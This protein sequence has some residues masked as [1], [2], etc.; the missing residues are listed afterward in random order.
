MPFLETTE[1]EPKS[2]PNIACQI[3]GHRQPNKFFTGIVNGI[4]LALTV[5]GSI[6]AMMVWIF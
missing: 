3:T 1:I 4:I 5:W 6:Y 2:F